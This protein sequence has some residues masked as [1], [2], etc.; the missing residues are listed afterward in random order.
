MLEKNNSVRKVRRFGV[1][2]SPFDPSNGV[3]IG[4]AP[5]WPSG[6]IFIDCPNT[7]AQYSPNVMCPNTV[8]QCVPI[9]L[10]AV[11]GL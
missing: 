1:T 8:T 9:Q 4:Y 11:K 2:F 10:V 6:D 5:H 7:V 3:N